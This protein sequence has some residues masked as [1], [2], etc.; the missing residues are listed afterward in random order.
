MTNQAISSCVELILASKHI[1]IFTGAGISTDSGIPDFRS[2]GSIWDRERPIDYHEFIY[3]KA[4][5][6][7]A[8][9]RKFSNKSLFEEA[10]PNAGHY[11]ISELIR[12]YGAKVVITQNIDGLH[13]AAGTPDELVIELHGNA[14]YAKCLDCQKRFELDAIEAD[15]RKTREP[16]NC[17]ECDG[18][19]KTAT[20]S[21][22]Q[23]LPE[24]A[25][26]AANWQSLHCDLIIAMGSTLAVTPA[27]SFPVQAKNNGSKLMI[28]NREPTGLDEIADLVIHEEI[29]PTLSECLALLRTTKK[30][31]E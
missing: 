15:F 3:S 9:R 14:R 17:D 26:E 11:A 1:V 2:P 19:V 31:S 7:E 6:R 20:I 13:Q 25:F 16:P 30:R 21:F 10:K 12:D 5:R 18:I 24:A 8:W 27:A 29:G 22:G 28:I 4:K 23:N